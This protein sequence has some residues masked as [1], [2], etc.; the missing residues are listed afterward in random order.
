MDLPWSHSKWVT[1]FN[2][3]F[4]PETQWGEQKQVESAVEKTFFKSQLISLPG[5]NMVP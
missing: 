4:K 5:R 3:F 2:L 1:I